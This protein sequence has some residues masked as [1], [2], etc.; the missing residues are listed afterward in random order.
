MKLPQV[1]LDFWRNRIVV[2]NRIIEEPE[3][4]EHERDEDEKEKQVII[5]VKVE[6]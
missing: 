5:A 4:V 1:F 3:S 6:F 2:V